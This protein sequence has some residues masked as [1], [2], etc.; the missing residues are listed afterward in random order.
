MTRAV[1]ALAVLFLA[2][3]VAN[4]HAQVVPNAYGYSPYGYYG[5]GHASTAAEGYAN[6]MSN[7][8]Q[9]AGTYN[10]QTSEAANNYRASALD[11]SRQS[12]EGH[13]NLL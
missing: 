13:T 7:I 1:S 9:S 6:G 3:L 8:I 10:L 11:G 5:G 2:T 12:F 4:A